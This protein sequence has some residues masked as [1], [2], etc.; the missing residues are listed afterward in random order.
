VKLSSRSKTRSPL[1]IALLAAGVSL[2]TMS[3]S[4]CTDSSGGLPGTGGTAVGGQ[5]G[6][7][8]GMAGGGQAGGSAGNGGTAVGG[9]AGGSAGNGGAAAA[10]GAGNGGAAAGNGGVAGGSAGHAGAMGGNAMPVG[11]CA[12]TAPATSGVDPSTRLDALTDAQK[13]AICDWAAS[14]YCGYDK[15][16]QCPDGSTIDSFPTQAMCVMNMDNTS[17]AATVADTEACER[18][19]TCDN[20]FPPSCD[21]LA[22]CP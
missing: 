19:A 9:Q 11:A 1:V 12:A 17:C 13:A 6:N 22:A 5:L 15:H 16:F 14:R 20:P 7:A 4:G 8:G 2:S 18:D 21:P 10:G 3:G